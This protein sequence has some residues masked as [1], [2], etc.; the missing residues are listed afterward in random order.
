MRQQIHAK[1]GGGQRTA[2]KAASQ[3][4]EFQVHS[5]DL[6]AL[7]VDDEADGALVHGHFVEQELDAIDDLIKLPTIVF[8]QQFELLV[9][10]QLIAAVIFGEVH[11]VEIFVI[12][13]HVMQRIHA[14]L[15]IGDQLDEFDFGARDVSVQF[16]AL[17]HVEHGHV[18]V[19]EDDV[20]L[21]LNAKQLVPIFANHTL[22]DRLQAMKLKR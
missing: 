2:A 6:I 13:E 16:D 7:L 10:M 14:R 8:Q 19:V 17:V 4:R 5:D 11:S 21:S 15:H 3:H 12:V 1:D 22:D 9:V 20:A 18:L